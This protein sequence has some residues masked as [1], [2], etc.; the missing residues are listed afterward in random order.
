MWQTYRVIDN[1]GKNKYETQ[2]QSW[3]LLEDLTMYKYGHKKSLF[4]VWILS[5]IG[6]QLMSNSFNKSA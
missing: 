2:M 4:S 6:I 1:F 5:M 3:L